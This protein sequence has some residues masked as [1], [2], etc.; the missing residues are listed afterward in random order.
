MDEKVT[1]KVKTDTHQ[2][3]QIVKGMMGAKTFGE[4]IQVMAEEYI[5]QRIG[6]VKK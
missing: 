3:L 6:K 5:E 4:A 2:K 1:M